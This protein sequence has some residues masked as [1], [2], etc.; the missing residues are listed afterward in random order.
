MSQYR[1]SFPIHVRYS[2]IDAQGHVNNA[3]FLTYLEEARVGYWMHLGLWDG[4]SFMDVGG[5]VADV[6]IT[7]LIPITFGQ[8]IIVSLRTEK[9]G[10]KSIKMVYAITH[11]QN[12]IIFATAETVVV[13]YDYHTY[14]TIRIPDDWR[15]IILA[16]DHPKGEEH[17]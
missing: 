11:A 13:T 15:T 10:N 7:Y 14:Q 16:Y 2:D 5:I 3:A 8:P 1:F 6:H 17:V 12:D 4:E 9:L